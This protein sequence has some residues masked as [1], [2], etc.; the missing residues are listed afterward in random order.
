MRKDI[1]DFARWLDITMENQELSNRELSAKIG[2]NESMTSRWRSARSAPS[3]ENCEKLADALGV[4][5][6]ALAVTAGLMDGARLGVEPLATP[7]PTAVRSRIRAQL[8]RIP[9]LTEASV[10]AAL[11]QWDADTE[12]ES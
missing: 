5:F 10:D 12:G 2:V 4:D 6:L 7:E 3:L 8:R 11:A 1:R 9:G